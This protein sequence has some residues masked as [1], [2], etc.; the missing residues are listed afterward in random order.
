MDNKIKTKIN[1]KYL[2]N[3]YRKVMWK[4]Y[5]ELI[6]KIETVIPISSAYLVGSF[7][8]SK[9]RPA[10]VDLLLFTKTKKNSNEDWAIDLEIVPDNKF[11]KE[12]LKDVKK[13]CKEK[14]KDKGGVLKL[15]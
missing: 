9:E 10:D 1:K 15:K 5:E 4:N 3:D 7:A 12:A 13:W 2:N 6:K 14:Y 11:G 8:S